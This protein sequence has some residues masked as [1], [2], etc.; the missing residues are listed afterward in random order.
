MFLHVPE[1]VAK[2]ECSGMETRRLEDINAA[3]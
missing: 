3:E 1:E 2:D